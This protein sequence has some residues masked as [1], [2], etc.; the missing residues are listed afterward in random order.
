MIKERWYLHCGCSQHIIGNKSILT[1]LQVSNQD[2]V[3][4]ND[5][6]RGRIIGMCSLII[7]SLSGLKD[8][9]VVEGVTINLISLSH[10]CEEN[11]LAQF[12][13][14]KCIVHNQ[15]HYL[16]MEGQRTLYNCYL[17]T[18]T[19]LGVNKI[20]EEHRSRF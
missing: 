6:A 14:D 19:S 10:L 13:R 4:F 9:L 20:Q 8:V 16:V 3:I 17:L 15:N 18:S 7:P 11:L 2:S 12:T 1:N 5:D